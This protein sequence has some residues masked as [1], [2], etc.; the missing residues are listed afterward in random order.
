METSDIYFVFYDGDS[1]ILLQNINSKQFKFQTDDNTEVSKESLLN[2]LEKIEDPADELF[3]V[4]NIK[5]KKNTYQELIQ[6]VFNSDFDVRNSNLKKVVNFDT[7]FLCG[8]ITEILDEKL[9]SRS[10][11]IPLKLLIKNLQLEICH[12]E[13]YYEGNVVQKIKD[14]LHDAKINITSECGVKVNFYVYGFRCTVQLKF[15]PDYPWYPV[16]IMLT[17]PFTYVFP[18]VHVDLQMG[19]SLM[20][21][22]MALTKDLIEKW[23]EMASR[24]PKITGPAYLVLGAHPYEEPH[25]RTHYDNPNVFFLDNLHGMP[26]D[27]AYALRGHNRFIHV[28]FSSPV[29][30]SILAGLLPNT[31]D[32]ICFDKSTFKFFSNDYE[33]D[34]YSRYLQDDKTRK[35]LP[36]SMLYERL[37][38][39]TRMLKNTG[40]M[41]LE[42]VD[43]PSGGGWI[44]DQT[45][46]IEYHSNKNRE[47]V[48]DYCKWA[49]L[50]VGFKTVR[51]IGDTS[52]LVPLLY[53]RLAGWEAPRINPLQCELLVAHKTATLS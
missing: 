20:E 18:K 6:T 11:L 4:C 24:L 41:F 26:D 25:G 52:F 7:F 39:L 34:V 51:E 15:T 8:K 44:G 13:K 14:D 49:G 22:S 16:D 29:E 40:T 3:I 36:G 5:S 1:N 46:N 42:H 21:D 50:D 9:P 30:M 47:K 35:N 53:S 23:E 45:K 17:E 33:Y 28:D 2:E 12:P 32:E 10:V 43:G 38:C 37:H 48:V 27:Y 19:N 31:F